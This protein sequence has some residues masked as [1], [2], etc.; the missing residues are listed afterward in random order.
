MNDLFAV[1]RRSVDVMAA[2]A[3][4]LFLGGL[5]WSLLNS[6]VGMMLLGPALV[7]LFRVALRAGREE[8]VDWQD[9][10]AAKDDPASALVAGILFAAPFLLWGMLDAVGE[11]LESGAYAR[12]DV[13]GVPVVL[14]L[15]VLVHFG[16]HVLAFAEL[17]DRR[18]GVLEAFRSARARA[19]AADRS[20]HAVTGFAKHLLLCSAALVMVLVADLLGGG[21]AVVGALLVGLAGPAAI[22]VLATWHLSVSG[23]LPADDHDAPSPGDDDAPSPGDDDAPSPDAASSSDEAPA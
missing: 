11:A 21:H 19:E 10:V 3:G 12:A 15:A 5:A 2:A 7:G 8:E 17:A 6:L 14:S 18:C 1:L 16:Y 23:T 13:P 20:S 4:P 22:A 9:L